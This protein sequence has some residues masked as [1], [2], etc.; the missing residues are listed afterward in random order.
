MTHSG[1]SLMDTSQIN[2]QKIT[3]VFK[4]VFKKGRYLALSLAVFIVGASLVLLLPNLS[5]L[6]QAL[7]SETLSAGAKLT[8]WI[9][10]YGSIATNY[11]LLNAISI[12][13]VLL[14]LSIEVALLVFYL[15]RVQKA[16]KGF[17]G[18]Q[19]KGLAGAISGVLGIGCAACGSVILTGIAASLGVT[20][21]LL[22]LPLHG[23]E[24]ALLGIVLLAWSIS[25]LV[26]KI[27]DPLV[28]PSKG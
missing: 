25:Y 23:G 16:T 22:A 14:L 21:L 13:L 9:A 1:H 8:F 2:L 20:G 3:T 10:L 11:T 4:R 6:V 5:T 26:K 17:K 28:C 12:F 7:T 19:I 24:F 27:Y 15:R 18:S